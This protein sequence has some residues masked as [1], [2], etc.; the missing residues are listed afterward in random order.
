MALTLRED[1]P[2]VLLCARHLDALYLLGDTSGR[3]F[4][5]CFWF[6]GSEVINVDLGVWT[7]WM[8]EDMSSNYKEATNLVL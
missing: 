4:R 1:L 8:T 7:L 2:E 3:S 5:C 6:Q